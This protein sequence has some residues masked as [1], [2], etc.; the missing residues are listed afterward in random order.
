MPFIKYFVALY[1]DYSQL[2]RP[3]ID[4]KNITT[5][6]WIKLTYPYHFKLNEEWFNYTK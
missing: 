5:A 2:L 3:K 1:Y 6:F 4:E